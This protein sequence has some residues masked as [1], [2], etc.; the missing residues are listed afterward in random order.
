[1]VGADR[2]A[3][4]RARRG[5]S[6]P[7]AAGQAG[8]TAPTVRLLESGGGRLESLIGLAGAVGVTLRLV[9][10]GA[11]YLAPGGAGLSSAR[12]GT[13]RD[14][15]WTPPDLLATIQAALG[16][17]ERWDL[18]PCSPGAD[19]SHVQAA[20][21]VTVAE[22]SLSLP[23]WGKAGNTA[24]VNPPFSRVA[25]FAERCVVEAGRGLRLVLLAPARPGSR[26]WR[27]NVVSNGVADVAFLGR[28]LAFGGPSGPR[29]PAPFDVALVC[30]GWSEGAADRLAA[31]LPG[32]WAMPARRVPLAARGARNNVTS[33]K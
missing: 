33:L 15:W 14:E 6:V 5:W 13:G 10:A 17:V 4:A 1:L 32:A 12:D 7:E 2:L 25:E 8:L 29:G 31:A 30:W 28:R 19:V 9:E 22:D 16:V 3:A 18:D 27:E 21:H 11:A 20:R 24:F 23:T 26:W